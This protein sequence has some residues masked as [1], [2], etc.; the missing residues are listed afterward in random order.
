MFNNRSLIGF[1]IQ[2]GVRVSSQKMI[3]LCSALMFPAMGTYLI[4]VSIIPNS[5]VVVIW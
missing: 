5:R 4:R 2:I 1:I 3:I